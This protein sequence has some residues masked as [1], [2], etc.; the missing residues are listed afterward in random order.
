MAPLA[1]LALA[2]G[3]QVSGS[4]LADNDKCRKLAGLGA[5]VVIGHAPENVPD[6]C[7]LL[8]YS[9]AVTPENCERIR[10]EQLGIPQ[11]RR[12]EY[13]AVF[14]GNYSRCVSVTGS[15]GKSSITALLV[16][17]LRQCGKNPGFMIGA[18]VK[19]LPCC[20]FG[21]GD[22]FVTEADESDGTHTLL[23][24]FLAVVPNVE[25]DHAWS[26]G[27]SAALDQNFRTV[28]EKSRHVICYASGKCDELFSGHPRLQRLEG[29]PETFAGLYGFQAVNAYIAW[30]A[31]VLLG[32]D[33]VAAEAAAAHYPEV[34]RRMNLLREQNGVKIVEDYAHH[35]TEVRCS[36]ELLRK[37]YPGCH[38]RIVFQP[39]RYARLQRYFREF[40]EVL[41]LADSCFILPV[42][43]AW[44]ESGEVDNYALA[45]ACGGTGLSGDWEL[46]GK[47]VRK[48]LPVPAVIAVLGAGDCD[49]ILP[50]L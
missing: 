15:H 27:G 8:V 1:E 35:P 14:A 6:D 33:P 17:I 13:L 21:D 9:S 50:F 24:N 32:C 36:L 41:K 42:F 22:I 19:A 30:H 26:V 11:L 12:G 46:A 37:K 43:A 31:A 34:A 10:A 23:E 45:R 49:N 47:T 20:A 28:A 38:L 25:D 5:D 29:C 44:S 7:Q 18:S 39:H 16:S 48:D 4:D 40:S 3:C 2:K